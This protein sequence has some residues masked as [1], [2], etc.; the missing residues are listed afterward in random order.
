MAASSGDVDAH[1]EYA[2]L[3]LDG[4]IKASETVATAILHIAANKG[5]LKGSGK[6]ES[7]GTVAGTLPSIQVTA[8][9]F[10][11]IQKIQPFIAIQEFLVSFT[12]IISACLHSIFDQNTLN[13]SNPFS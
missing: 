7:H 10:L 3:V 2:V 1:Y 4:H 6:V 11:A 8:T 5:S 12:D 9:S 13:I